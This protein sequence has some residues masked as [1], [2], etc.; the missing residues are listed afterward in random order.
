MT[1]LLLNQ[2]ETKQKETNKN[3][4]KQIPQAKQAEFK[5]FY[6]LMQKKASD[7]NEGK[8]QRFNM[9]K[10]TKIVTISNFIKA[11][12]N[13]YFKITTITFSIKK[14]TC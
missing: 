9:N 5:L 12:K 8:E 2:Q 1:K 10:N 14:K 6:K 7:D 11:E 4:Y 3:L 13:R